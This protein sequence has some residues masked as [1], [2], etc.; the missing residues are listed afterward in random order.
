MDI[1]ERQVLGI[2]ILNYQTWQLTAECIK[3]I[4]KDL[5]SDYKIFIVDNASPNCSYKKLKEIF[6]NDPT[7]ECLL[8]E[9]N[10]GYAK[11]NNIGIKACRQD[12]IEYAL[13]TNNDVEF[14]ESAIIKMQDTLVKNTNAVIVSPK[15]LKKNGQVDSIPF[16]DV[17][18]FSQ[19]LGIRSTEK[20]HVNVEKVKNTTKVYS[21][22]GCCI[23]IDVDKFI[24]MGAFDEGTFMYCE[25]GT[26]AKQAWNAGYDVLFE[27]ASI[28]VHAHG[29]STGH[30]NVFIDS[31]ILRSS[32]YYWRKYENISN[33][34]LYVMYYFFTAKML[35]KVLLRRID[36]TGG[37]RVILRENQRILRQVLRIKREEKE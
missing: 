13:I 5:I 23:M 29:A 15:I 20:L 37:L 17:Q 2:V 31:N 19:Y 27:P 24:D 10:G 32:L 6:Q 16:Y 12:N 9:E 33:F 36:V 14:Y 3:K 11:G 21:V 35:V 34:K 22:P 8:A 18:T 1:G 26:M 25:E 4:K 7:V 30:R 28:I